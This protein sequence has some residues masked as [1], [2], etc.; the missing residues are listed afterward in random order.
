[1][2]I[3]IGAGEGSPEES[4]G[5]ERTHHRPHATLPSPV[6][7]LVHRTEGI[8]DSVPRRL[9]ARLVRPLLGDVEG[10]LR[11]KGGGRSRGGGDGG[12]GGGGGEG[13][14]ETGSGGEGASGE[15]GT[16][17]REGCERTA[18]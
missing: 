11:N 17:S 12:L 15:E 1:M 10:L 18:S 14:G 7:D 16:G 3:G 13:E 9:E 2:A 5:K 6:D 8:L 4:R